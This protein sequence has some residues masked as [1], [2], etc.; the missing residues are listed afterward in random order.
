MKYKADLRSE[1]GA[2]YVLEATIVYPIVLVAAMFMIILGFTHLQKS[3]LQH[4]ATE[5]S[6]YLAKVIRYPGYEYIET[7]FYEKNSGEE[8]SAADMDKRVNKAMERV[9][10]YRYLFNVFTFKGDDDLISDTAKEMV[11]TY[12]VKHGYVKGN[13]KS[14]PDT[15]SDIGSGESAVGAGRRCTI[16]AN[17]SH[18]T[19]YIGQNYILSS[20]YRMIGLGGKRLDLSGQATAY[21]CDSVEIVRLTDTAFDLANF[22]AGKLGIDFSKISGYISKLT[23][24]G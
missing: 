22:I 1:D 23:G 19:V 12:L 15:P 6:T 24:N 21:V 16:V 5:L 13:E 11:N 9:E 4:S 18:V 17:S 20:L 10:P 3:F 2:A 7:P 8:V 14:I